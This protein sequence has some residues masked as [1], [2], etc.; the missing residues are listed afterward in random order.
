MDWSRVHL[1]WGDERFLAA[2]DEERNETGARSALLTQ[3][4]V[5]A[6]Q[7]HPV[8]GPDGPDGDDPQAA[9]DRY[10]REL[11]ELAD[12]GRAAPAFDVLILGVGPDG[13]VASLFPGRPELTEQDRPVVVVRDSPK[14]PPTRLSLTYPVINASRQVWLL[15]SGEEKADAVA[16]G[17]AGADPSGAPCAGVHGVDSTLWLLDRAAA[18]ATDLDQLTTQG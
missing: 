10:S 1:W 6:A 11:A 2:G 18:S 17:L 12:P 9:A 14:P 15:A 5:V 4:P 16:G 13:H 3:D 8:P 7:V